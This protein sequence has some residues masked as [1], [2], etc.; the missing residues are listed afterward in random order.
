MV[1][2][3]FKEL[4]ASDFVMKYGVDPELLSGYSAGRRK[5][6]KKVLL[7]GVFRTT[8]DGESVI[9][10]DEKWGIMAWVD[11]DGFIHH[12]QLV[13]LDDEHRPFLG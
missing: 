8:D 4:A 2:K 13:E 7:T 1:N 5:V 3:K 12:L 11:S 10:L 9:K 6:E